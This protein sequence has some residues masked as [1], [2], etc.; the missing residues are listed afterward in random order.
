VINENARLDSSPFSKFWIHNNTSLT[1]RVSQ[2]RTPKEQKK[3][4]MEMSQ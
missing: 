1:M 3:K 2:I 4:K